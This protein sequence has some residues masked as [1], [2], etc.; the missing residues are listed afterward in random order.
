MTSHS[1]SASRTTRLSLDISSPLMT[2]HFLWRLMREFFFL[3]LANKK[4][5]FG[6]RCMDQAAY[7][8]STVLTN[9][10]TSTMM[11]SNPLAQS[12]D[13]GASVS[14]DAKPS[15][16]TSLD[17]DGNALGTESQT[18]EHALI[19]NKVQCVECD[20]VFRSSQAVNDHGGR[21]G[22]NP[23]SCICGSAFSRSDALSRHLKA[24]AP[25]RKLPQHPCPHCRRHRGMDGFR[26]RDHLI[27]HLRT[28]H[29]FEAE[30]KIHITVKG[31]NYCMFVPTCPY[32]T[33]PEYRR[34][35]FHC[36]P[37]KE[38]DRTKPFKNRQEY[39]KH[40]RNVHNKTPFSC[41]LSGCDRVGA[42]GF[43]REKAFINHRRL[44]HP[45][46]PPYDTNLEGAK[47]QCPFPTCGERLDSE[48]ALWSH[49][50]NAH[51][52]SEQRKAYWL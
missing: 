15:L 27:Q 31:L 48:Y 37:R 25:S 34:P 35:E 26:R 22:H 2:Q 12:H 5:V 51:M 49:L 39:T 8:R 14:P 13:T 16:G 46:A 33:C 29:K 42:K 20:E 21:S 18:L 41:Q 32:S 19:G 7:Q 44:H 11:H 3:L 45:E 40:M 52:T 6:R 23:F 43:V 36:L 1:T 47:E 9:E 28:Y 30:E 50:R 17:S 24:K 10:G 38:Q 4:G